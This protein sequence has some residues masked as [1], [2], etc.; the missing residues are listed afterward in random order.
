ML[1]FIYYSIHNMRLK[2]LDFLRA[3]AILLVIGRHWYLPTTGALSIWA[4]AGWAGVDLFFVISGFLISGLLFSEY[5]KEGK[6]SFPRFFV[7]RGFKIYPAFFVFLLL[8][9]IA[10]T[11]TTGS[12]G[13]QVDYKKSTDTAHYYHEYFFLQDY[14]PGV[15]PHTWSLAVEE[16]FYLLLPLLLILLIAYSK[17]KEKLE[18]IPLMFVIIAVGCL[19]MRYATSWLTN[20]YHVYLRP[21]HL[22]MDALFFG[23]LIS[24]LYHFKGEKFEAWIK[25]Y[26]WPVIIASLL[27]ISTAFIFDLESLFMHTS[28]LTLL[29]LGFGGI[30]AVMVYSKPITNKW[31]N[32]LASIGVY[33]YSIYLWHITVGMFLQT[34]LRTYFPMTY[35][36]E[37]AIYLLMTVAFGILMAKIVEFPMLK[38]R[39]WII[40]KKE[41]MFVK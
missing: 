26:K 16:K 30:L 9:P 6:I 28:G 31:F 24:Y 12:F 34:N 20:D 3:I 35:G 7:R 2:Q 22:R 37:F 18:S 38:L 4:K 15:F 1:G 5:K 27:F 41:E 39:D 40:P 29:Y 33:S 11:I 32:G 14:F 13:T 8:A 23:V 19:A 17:R 36:I 21:F 25:K 10:L